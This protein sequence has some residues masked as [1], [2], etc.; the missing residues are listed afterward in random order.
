MLGGHAWAGPNEDYQTGAKAYREGDLIGAMAPLRRSADA[1][2]AGAQALLGYILD[3][4][5]FDEE[6]VAYFR[7]SAAQGHADGQYGLGAMY[8]A[9][10]GVTKDAAEARRL[11]TLAADQGHQLATNTLAQAYLSGN[12]GIGDAERKS[13]EALARL[14]KAVDLDYLPAIDALAA[15]YRS[16]D[17]GLTTDAKEA[18]RLTAHASKLRGVK[19]AARGRSGQAK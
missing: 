1:G 3:K 10:E 17:Y 13:P 16:G 8:A 4:A 12:L 19:K 2:H 11:I 14:R 7:K 6:A 5:E 15:A 18:E 9:G